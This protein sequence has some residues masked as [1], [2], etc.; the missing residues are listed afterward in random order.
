[1][2]TKGMTLPRCF[3]KH[4]NVWFRTLTRYGCAER[5]LSGLVPFVGENPP[6]RMDRKGLADVFEKNPH[7]ADLI[8]SYLGKPKD[9][10]NLSSVSRGLFL[11]SL[12][13]KIFYVKGRLAHW[14]TVV[15]YAEVKTRVNR[16]VEFSAPVAKEGL[17]RTLQHL[18]QKT[19]FISVHELRQLSEELWYVK[20]EFTWC[21]THLEV[22][23]FR[24]TYVNV[25]QILQGKMM[26][27]YD[28]SIGVIIDQLKWGCEKF[29]SFGVMC[30]CY[31]YL[32]A[33][34]LL[35][36]KAT[37]FLDLIIKYL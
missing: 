32:L 14:Q 27:K 16:V 6:P 4:V 29:G 5:Y 17:N 23:K 21:Y 9:V 15:Q 8:I 12:R 3:W 24:S 31:P 36:V 34:V 28:D 10:A 30:D 25:L 11:S 7:I 26:P 13:S 22:V 33:Y 1:M 20:R 35:N 19:R 18:C 2:R 37:I